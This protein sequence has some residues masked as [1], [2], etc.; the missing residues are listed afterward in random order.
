MV[1]SYR[2]RELPTWE[3]LPWLTELL[4]LVPNTRQVLSAG[5]SPANQPDL[6]VGRLIDRTV[7]TEWASESTLPR[8]ITYDRRG[9][10]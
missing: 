1:V 8:S 7:L 6:D 2:V 4:A 5:R 9:D 3:A 10:Y